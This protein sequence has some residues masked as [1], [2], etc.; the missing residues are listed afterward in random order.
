MAHMIQCR[1]TSQSA[2]VVLEVQ[3]ENSKACSDAEPCAI[4]D[5]LR[6][7]EEEGIT[8]VKVHG[9][10]CARP[11]PDSDQGLTHHDHGSTVGGSMFDCVMLFSSSFMSLKV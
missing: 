9:H 4:G 5:L 6:E 2:K 11:A 1:W 8:D 3:S 7:M 10:S